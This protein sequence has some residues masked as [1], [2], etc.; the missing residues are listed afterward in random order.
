LD[1]SLTLERDVFAAKR[2]T[3]A[4]MRALSNFRSLRRFERECLRTLREYVKTCKSL[5]EFANPPN[6]RGVRLRAVSY[7]SLLHV[8]NRTVTQEDSS[9]RRKLERFYKET[10][11]ICSRH[12]LFADPLRSPS[13]RGLQGAIVRR[14]FRKLF[15][16]ELDSMAVHT[17]SRYGDVASAVNDFL[18]H[19][20]CNGCDYLIQESDMRSF[21]VF[22]EWRHRELDAQREISASPARDARLKTGLRSRFECMWLEAKAA[23]RKFYFA[24]DHRVL[25]QG[26]LEVRPTARA[27]LR[28]KR[29]ALELAS[30]AES[31]RFVADNLGFEV[32]GRGMTALA[33]FADFMFRVNPI[34]AESSG[35]EMA[36]QMTLERLRRILLE[37]L[38][39][40][41]PA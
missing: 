41:S 13:A 28:S 38:E 7:L 27:A 23:A 11:E 9:L 8:E 36:F 2:V 22:A 21:L 12:R 10:A 18:G 29:V 16:I 1:V 15:A 19:C 33:V 20:G 26:W 17:L 40:A 39:C 24:H 31:Q 25:K 14:M 3:A 4:W 30:D 5:G 34:A 35:H 37:F 6:L 32:Y